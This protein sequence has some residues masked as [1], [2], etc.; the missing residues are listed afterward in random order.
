[1]LALVAF[2]GVGAGAARGFGDGYGIDVACCACEL[3][4]FGGEVGVGAARAGD[5]EHAR[6]VSE[7]LWDGMGEQVEGTRTADS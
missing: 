1:M 2:F 6:E 4:G 3:D 7:G 5:D